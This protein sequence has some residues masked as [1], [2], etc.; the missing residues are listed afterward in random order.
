MLEARLCCGWPKLSPLLG[1]QLC[2]KDIKEK[3]PDGV[4]KGTM[5][6]LQ[7]A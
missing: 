6:G 4:E 2:Q 1:G 5:Q 3:V 7:D